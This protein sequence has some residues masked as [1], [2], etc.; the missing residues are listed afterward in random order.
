[1]K[2]TLWIGGV[3]VLVE[4]P[5]LFRQMSRAQRTRSESCRSG[6]E[7]K[8]TDWQ[9]QWSRRR[10]DLGTQEMSREN[11]GESSAKRTRRESYGSSSGKSI[12]AVSP[13]KSS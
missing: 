9:N 1:M 5:P 4:D 12:F 10:E 7:P 6:D 2:L 8:V 11:V 3:R 13:T